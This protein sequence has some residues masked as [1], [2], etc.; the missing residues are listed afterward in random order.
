MLEEVFDM[1]TELE[2]I[3]LIEKVEEMERKTEILEIV[4]TS[5]SEIVDSMKGRCPP[6]IS[7]LV[8]IEQDL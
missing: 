5:V 7:G 6:S 4:P 2:E 1:E 8:E 3:K